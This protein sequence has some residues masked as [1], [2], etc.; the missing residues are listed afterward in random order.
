MGHFDVSMTPDS[1]R[2][3]HCEAVLTIGTDARLLL[4][5]EPIPFVSS[6]FFGGAEASQDTDVGKAGALAIQ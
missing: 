2:W 5:K 3:S 6:Q 1:Q 4:F